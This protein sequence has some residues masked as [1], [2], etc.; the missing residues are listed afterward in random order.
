[1]KIT[2]E[3]KGDVAIIHLEGKVM[4]GPDS[5]MFHGK[6]HELANGGTKKVVI[7][8]AKVEWMSS[9]GLGMLISALT[10][11]KN[12]KG[13]LKL[14]NVTK[15]IESLLTI[16]RLVTIFETHDSLD[17]AVKSF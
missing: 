8:L 15:G 6:L 2:D 13:M 17:E 5:T 9:V 3:V 12:N 4:G 10:T 14:A 7:D 16:T 11:M 1:M